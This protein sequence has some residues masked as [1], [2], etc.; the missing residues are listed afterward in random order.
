MPVY[1]IY[2]PSYS[3]PQHAWEPQMLR[4]LRETNCVRTKCRACHAKRR[5]WAPIAALPT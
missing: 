4:R 3:Q 5:A 1:Y 2:Y